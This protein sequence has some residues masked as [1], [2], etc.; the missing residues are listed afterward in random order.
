MRRAGETGETWGG[1]GPVGQEPEC[2]L[3]LQTQALCDFQ[4]RD[5]RGKMKGPR[6]ITVNT[7]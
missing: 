1:A 3:D 7:P 2:E 4:R 5:E 6:K